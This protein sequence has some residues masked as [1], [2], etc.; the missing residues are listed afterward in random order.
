M[1]VNEGVAALRES[2]GA[3]L[4]QRDAI[5]SPSNLIAAGDQLYLK[6]MLD[7]KAHLL[8]LQQ[9][10]GKT[11]WTFPLT[12]EGRSHMI[13]QEGFLFLEGRTGIVVI[14]DSL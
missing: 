1:L 12:R 7:D 13:Y 6:T 4:W 14:G 9:S 2:D 11:V 10:A 8:A 5:P 3:L